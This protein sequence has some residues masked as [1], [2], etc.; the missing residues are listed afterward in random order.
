[1]ANDQLYGRSSWKKNRIDIGEEGQTVDVSN[2][3]GASTLGTILRA[4]RTGDYGNVGNAL[5]LNRNVKVVDGTED[6]TPVVLS[7]KVVTVTTFTSPD[8]ANSKTVENEATVNALQTMGWTV[9][10]VN[11]RIEEIT[12]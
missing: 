10:D 4:N 6:S 1:M 9:T 11:E 7:R 3:I 8:G 2:V 5:T 12:G